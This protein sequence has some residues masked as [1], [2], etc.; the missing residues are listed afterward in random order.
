MQSGSNEFGPA[1]DRDDRGFGPD[2]RSER[3]L[4]GH[5]HLPKLGDDF[6]QDAARRIR[7]GRDLI[8]ADRLD[9][10]IEEL[11]AAAE[12]EPHDASHHHEVG[13]CLRLL[14]RHEEAAASLQRSVDLAPGDGAHRAELGAAMLDL[15]RWAEAAGQLSVAAR[16]DPR[17]ERSLARLVRAYAELGDHERAE[18]AFYLAQ[19]V[20]EE[21]PEAFDGVARSLA[22]R[23]LSDRAAW[24]WRHAEKLALAAG[25]DDL[26][27]DT[28]VCRADLCRDSGQPQ[29][30]R[31]LYLQALGRSARHHEA[32]LGLSKLLLELRQYEDAATRIKLAVRQRPDDPRG[33]FLAGRRFLE[34]GRLGEASVA[35]RRVIELD[36]SFPRAHL[37][38]AR[39]A[40]REEDPA[41]VRRFCRLEMIRR[42]TRPEVLRELGNLLLDVADA[43]RA[44]A[45]L[46]R[47]VAIA[48][49][50]ARGWQDLGVAECL[51]GRHSA[52]V[53]ASRRAMKLDPMNL[54][55]TNNLALA[56]L[57]SG[58]ADAAWQV[59]VDGLRQDPRHRLLRRLRLRL[60]LRRAKE[61]LRRLL[62]ISTQK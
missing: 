17:D 5:L 28:L 37:L 61:Q 47:L 32:L 10:A 12:L 20:A 9:E 8:H 51:R 58:D 59:V 21:R 36:T 29:E 62:R 2:A 43:D 39:L 46:R 55:A 3:R 42:P 24:C 14:E 23:G 60:R 34:T 13:L 18:Q 53:V 45:C 1:R 49:T 6:W 15:G 4:P 50:D 11:R 54:T 27:V 31:R 44:A 56:L 30:A 48:P 40:V 7:R 33:H 25:R 35:L 19:Q 52:G 26:A 16:L 57:E 41:A 22:A 38:L